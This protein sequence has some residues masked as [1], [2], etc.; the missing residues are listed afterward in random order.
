[1]ESLKEK[2]AKGM[3]WGGLGNGVQQLIGL[4]FGIYLA[5]MLAPEDYGMMAMISIFSLIATALQN[6]G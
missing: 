1:M 5:R 2:T 4:L 6:S 3:F